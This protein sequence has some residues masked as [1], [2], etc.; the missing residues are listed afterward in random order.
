[1]K[2]K[3][4]TIHSTG[5]FALIYIITLTMKKI[6]LALLLAMLVMG[7]KA[8]SSKI[9]YQGEVLAGYSVGVGDITS[10]R[11]NLHTVHGVRFNPYVFLGGG[12]GLDFYDMDDSEIAMPIYFN[13]KGYLPVSPKMNMFL[14]LDLGSSIGVSDGFSELSGLL[15]TPAVGVNF[16]VSQKN[17]LSLSV[18]YHA[19]QWTEDSISVNTDEIGRAHV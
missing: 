6:T 9:K 15:I 1:M 16:K 4:W 18:G 5:N 11:I 7:A 17:S 3:S 13:A 10:D 12:V 14:S 8:Q 19:Q 2:L